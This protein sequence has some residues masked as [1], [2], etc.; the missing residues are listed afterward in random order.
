MST[1][2]GHDISW[3]ALLNREYLPK[4]AT[5]ALALWL[6]ASNSMLTATTM[7][8]AVDE[9]GGLN[10]ISW[11]FAL[12]LAG[13]IS[14]A[15][16]ISLLIANQGLKAT[17][18][19]AAVVFS[20]GCVVVAT[21]PNMPVL[22]IGRVLQGLGGG[23]L[24][25]LVYVSQDRFFPNHL[26]P[27]MVALLSSVWM[28]AAFS[29][30]VIGGA[31]AT[32]GEWRLAYWAFAAQ[33]LLLIPAVHFLLKSEESELQLGAEPI[34]VVRLLLLS[35]SILLVSISGAYYHPLATP[36]LV[37]LG[38]MTLVLFVMRDRRASRAR[39][40][41]AE[42]ADFSHA[43][44]NGIVA[45][46]LLCISIMSFLVYGPLILIE[47]YGLTPLQAGFVVLIESL[48]WGSAAILFAG[49]P[50]ESEPRLIR[51][52]GSLVL[53]G[54]VVMALVL[55]RGWLW[56][57]VLAVIVLNGGFGM[58]WGFIIKRIVAA[59]APAD[60]DRT[61]SL[62][63]ITQQ[64]GFALGAALSGLVANSLAIDGAP[65]AAEFRLIAFWLFAGFVPLALV[66]N[67]MLWRFVSPRLAARQT[68]ERVEVRPPEQ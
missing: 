52:G 42:A 43:I 4:L 67:L 32:A 28:A 47:M 10:L 38:C 8:S 54:L 57:V 37:V 34:P 23:G 65:D 11:T 25:A 36:L 66:G 27:R 40:L 9:I 13:S 16:S 24:I 58:M 3:R 35:A 12:Y 55:P 26:V 29:G 18:I 59:A 20:I 51:I 45:T 15:A 53:L 31:F 62:L 64:T 22:L 19:R 60:K 44:G 14:A 7:P 5:M 2:R 61:A 21:A 48:A 50:H 6:H 49:V 17:M 56:S 41:P 63:P 33:G 68:L 1:T 46:L 39:M 30:P